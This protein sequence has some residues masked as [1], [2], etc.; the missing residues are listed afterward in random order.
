V[1]AKLPAGQ[2]VITFTGEDFDTQERLEKVFNVVAAACAFPGLFDSVK[3]PGLGRCVDG[4]VVNNAPIRYAVEHSAVHRVIVPI[5]FSAVMPKN[6]WGGGL[7][8]LNH[9]IAILINERLFRDLESAHAMNEQVIELQKMVAIGLINDGQKIN[10]EKKLKISQTEIIEIRPQI[11][12]N[13]S[14]FSAFFFKKERIALVQQGTLAT[15]AAL[16]KYDSL[17]KIE[18]H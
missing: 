5:P 16:A 14:P 2:E 18:I 17:K 12:M 11:H 1:V 15:S 6:D 4:G 9:L 7:N 3:I 13:C 8:L 10:I